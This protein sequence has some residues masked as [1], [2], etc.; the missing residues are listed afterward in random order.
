MFG[1]GQQFIIEVFIYLN[2]EKV[3]IMK[4]SVQDLG[5][6]GHKRIMVWVT[7]GFVR[8]KNKGTRLVCI[9]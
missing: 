6:D 5:K 4:I 1:C 9:Y 2:T 8:E 7:A 3:Q